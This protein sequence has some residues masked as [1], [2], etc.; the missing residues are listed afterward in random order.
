MS[1]ILEGKHIV[2]IGAS[3]GI[4]KAT[5]D[6]CAKRGARVSL[7]ARRTDRLK[8]IADELG[9]PHGYYELD[10]TWDRNRI[11]EVFDR[12]VEERG[13]IDGM[14]YSV[15]ISANMAFSVI[16]KTRFEE[17][18][19]TNLTGAMITTQ[20]A[21]NLK[22]VKREGLS[23]VWIASIAASKPSGGGLFMYSASKAAM[24]GGIR[25]I[26]IELVKRNIRIN[27][28]SP[29]AVKTEIWNQYVLSEKQKEELFKKHPLGIGE[30]RDIAAACTYLLSDD[31]KWITGQDFII[32][33][34]FSLT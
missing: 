12:I 5:A 24:I 10:V 8:E 27:T 19:N 21:I 6:L 33:G 13:L 11:E 25:S 18:L 17:V 7:C 29:G 1:C 2:I 4:G 31:A 23:I 16:T 28:I 32:D 14:V 20:A 22:R 30:P 34:G 3:S 9:T 26:S 15:G